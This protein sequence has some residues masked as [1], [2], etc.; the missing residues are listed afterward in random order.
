MT[1]VAKSSL[2]TRPSSY[3]GLI[4]GPA[5][6]WH[7]AESKDLVATLRDL[8]RRAANDVMSGSGANGDLTRCLTLSPRRN[9]I[10]CDV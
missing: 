3:A 8:G 1:T 5:S 9:K 2:E 7:D 4:D 6:G 10:G